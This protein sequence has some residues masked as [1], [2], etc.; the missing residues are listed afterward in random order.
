[1]SYV[2]AEP[3]VATCKTECLATCPVE[4]IHAPVS[5]DELQSVAEEDRARRFPGLQLY[6]DPA[7]CI[8]CGACAAACPVD[9]I[10]HEDDLPTAWASYR[11]KNAEF[12]HAR[13][14]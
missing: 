4:S 14:S 13:E 11:E 8:D 5:I 10:F 9:A 3:C 6:I 2:I 1:M 12:F 7:T